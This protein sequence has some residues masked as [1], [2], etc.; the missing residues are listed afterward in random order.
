MTSDTA[1]T[2]VSEQRWDPGPPLDAGFVDGEI[3]IREELRRGD[4]TRWRRAGGHELRERLT[5]RPERL[6][7]FQTEGHWYAGCKTISDYVL[8][9]G[10]P[11][12]FCSR[13][14]WYNVVGTVT[15]VRTSDTDARIIFEPLD[16]TGRRAAFE[17]I[18]P[19]TEI[20]HP[21]AKQ[22]DPGR[23]KTSP[24]DGWLVTEERAAFLGLGEQHLRRYTRERFRSWCE[25]ADGDLLAYDP[26][27]STGQFLSEFATM[28]PARIR[29]VGQ[30]LSS[31]MADFAA[32]RLERVV[33]GDAA[34]PAV[35]SGSVDILFSRF[36]NSEVVSTAQARS[37]LPALVDTLRPGGT[38]VLLGH[39]PVLLDAV[40][41]VSAGLRVRQTVA[42]Q[43]DHLF[44][45]YVCEHGA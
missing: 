42:R 9:Q 12:V 5:D 30:D 7:L 4:F 20:V 6:F 23:E 34:S 2:V 36:L 39:S 40:D 27:C 18:T 19:L 1:M 24:S 33:C 17:A 13:V 28:D 35:E 44:Q 26:A 21:F 45:Y 14:Y 15:S 16:E 11:G 38:M 37:L 41:L 32:S 10:M 22:R 43:D 8:D 3:S 25:A 29:T 31:Q